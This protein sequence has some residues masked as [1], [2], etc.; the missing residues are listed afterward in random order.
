M[1]GYNSNRL[2]VVEYTER[3]M[4]EWYLTKRLGGGILMGENDDGE[5]LGLE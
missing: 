4:G 2:W 1:G 3:I 5:R